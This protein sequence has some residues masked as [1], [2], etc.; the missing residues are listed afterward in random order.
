MYR[1]RLVL[2]KALFFIG[3]GAVLLALI[4]SL[5]DPNAVRSLLTPG[6]IISSFKREDAVVRLKAENYIPQKLDVCLYHEN[7]TFEHKG[8]ACAR[9]N[10]K[11]SLFEPEEKGTPFSGEAEGTGIPESPALTG[12]VAVSAQADIAGD[13]Q[14]LVQTIKSLFSSQAGGQARQLDVVYANMLFRLFIWRDM[15]VELREKNAWFGLGFGHPQRSRS[16]EILGWGNSEWQRDGYIT[17][18]NAF[19][20]YVYRAGIIGF[21]LVL[22]I[23]WMLAAMVR[24][25][26]RAGSLA[27]GLL[28]SALVFGL[29]Y[30]Q[31]SVF[32]ELPYNAIPFWALWGC[33]LAYAHKLKGI[34][35]SS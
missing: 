9:D 33:T 30:A 14:G 35:A 28:V 10:Y 2:G 16:L 22:V 8:T 1:R 19:L 5:A 6:K 23:M 12:K 25:F 34:H 27:G 11:D 31:F 29:V 18:H 24:D 7:D 15:L 3:G 20:H 32:L 13:D 21:G 4:F 17:P 26:I